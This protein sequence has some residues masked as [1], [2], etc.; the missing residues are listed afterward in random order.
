MAIYQ[1][2]PIAVVV[3][4]F[5]SLLVAFFSEKFARNRELRQ[6]YSWQYSNL[7]NG[8]DELYLSPETKDIRGAILKGIRSHSKSIENK[9]WALSVTLQRIALRVYVGV[10][11]IQYVLANNGYQLLSDWSLVYDF[12]KSIRTKEGGVPYSRRHAEWFVLFSFIWLKT[13][14]Y[15]PN[16]SQVKAME[17]ISALYGQFSTLITREAELFTNDIDLTSPELRAF[18]RKTLNHF[19]FDKLFHKVR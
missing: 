1:L 5:T 18:R 14:K 9:R 4:V 16:D 17:S 3:A 2:I 8:F 12:V 19:R 11:P 15:S 10:I 13:R 7:F 6:R